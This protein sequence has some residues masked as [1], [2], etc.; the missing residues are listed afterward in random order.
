MLSERLLEAIKKDRTYCGEHWNSNEEV[1]QW[2]PHLMNLYDELVKLEN[3]PVMQNYDR[4]Q[5]ERPDGIHT[6]D[7]KWK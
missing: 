6:I 4:W 2:A 1:R 3:G 7:K 5:I